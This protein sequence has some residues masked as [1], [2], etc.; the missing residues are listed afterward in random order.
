MINSRHEKG[1][2]ERKQYDK[3]IVKLVEWQMNYD[4]EYYQS[5]NDPY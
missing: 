3:Y 1:L 2:I 4:L 5:E